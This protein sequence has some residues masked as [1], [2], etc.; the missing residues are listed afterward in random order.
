MSSILQRSYTETLSRLP[1]TI[2]LSTPVSVP[3]FYP[4]PQALPGYGGPEGA[5]AQVILIFLFFTV[6]CCL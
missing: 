2:A 5:N 3:L 6:M 1:D 4:S